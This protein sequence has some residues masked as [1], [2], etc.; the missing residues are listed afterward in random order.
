MNERSNSVIKTVPAASALHSVPMFDPLKL[1]RMTTSA[2]TGEKVLRLD[3]SYKKMWFLLAHPRGRMLTNILRVTDQMAIFQAQLFADRDDDT[4][5]AQ[6]TSC[7]TRRDSGPQYIRN[8]QNEALNEALDNAGFGIQLSD[9]VEHDDNGY[10]S[11]VLLSQVEA[12][13]RDQEHVDPTEPTVSKQAESS[14]NP[15]PM[16]TADR[17]TPPPAQ[18]LVQEP[19]P[20][21]EKPTPVQKVSAAPAAKMV[22]K[23][24]PAVEAAPAQVTEPPLADTASDAETSVNNP[25]SVEETTSE[26]SEGSQPNETASSVYTETASV[27]QMLGG[28]PAA[29]GGPTSEQSGKPKTAERPTVV[30]FPQ[31]EES[32]QT[33]EADEQSAPQN[34]AE[35]AAEAA[36]SYTDDMTV[37][38]I[39]ARMTIEQAKALTV[40]FG[41]NKGWTLGQV[42]DRRPSSLKFYALVSQD[43]S[44]AIKAGSFLLLDEL[45]QARAG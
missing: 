44:N 35:P 34:D 13:L 20:P 24:A 30:A 28:I 6:F 2:K 39:R 42:Q 9:L 29:A 43:A 40:S 16:Q 12:L 27:L 32:T 23:A 21:Q 4:V 3:L 45:A 38:E 17:Q 5:L 41:P 22:E 10:G 11:E 26:L 15:A 37:D 31:A 33:V 18:E 1:L 8:A 19:A 25:K 7:H 14:A 36:V